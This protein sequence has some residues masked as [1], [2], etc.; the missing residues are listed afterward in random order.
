MTTNPLKLHLLLLFV[1]ALTFG[2]CGREDQVDE[3]EEALPGDTSEVIPMIGNSITD[4]L[5]S[6]PSFSL[7]MAALD[8]AGL[9]ETL[10]EP[11]PYTIFAPTDAAFEAVSGLMSQTDVASRDSLRGILLYHVVMDVVEAPEGGDTLAVTSMQGDDL[12]L[13]SENGALV[14]N[15]VRVVEQDIQAENGRIHVVEQVLRP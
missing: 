10:R 12:S 15:G 3:M 13:T 1:L 5:E 8:S 14:V 2:A 7:F 6:E 9:A 4:L 11:G